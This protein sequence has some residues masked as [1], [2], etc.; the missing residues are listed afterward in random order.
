[1]SK[2]YNDSDQYLTCH[3]CKVNKHTSHYRFKH[4]TCRMCLYLN[5][6]RF[7]HTKERF[8]ERA[9]KY[10]ISEAGFQIHEAGSQIKV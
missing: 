7:G 5:R 10:I 3:K 6:Y 1:M 8:K 2:H 9:E 4:Y